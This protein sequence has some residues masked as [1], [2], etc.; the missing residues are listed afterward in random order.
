MILEV[1]NNMVTPGDNNSNGVSMLQFYD[2]QDA[3]A[4]AEVISGS[5]LTNGVAVRSMSVVYNTYDQSRRWWFNG[6]EYTG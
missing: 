4:W 1:S 5:M 2:Y 3:V 6:V